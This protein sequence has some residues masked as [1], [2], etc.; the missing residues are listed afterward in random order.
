MMGEKNIGTLFRLCTPE[1]CSGL[2]YTGTKFRFKY[3]GTL[4]RLE[5]YRNEVPLNVNQNAVPVIFLN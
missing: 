2:N 5:L 1:R 4:F 3:T